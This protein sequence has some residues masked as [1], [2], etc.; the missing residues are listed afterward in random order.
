MQITSLPNQDS[1]LSGGQAPVLGLDVWEHAYYLKCQNRRAEYIENFFHVIKWNQIEKNYK[2]ALKK[3]KVR[4]NLR[5][6]Y[7]FLGPPEERNHNGKSGT[8]A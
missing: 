3:E 2:E 6:Q 1:P 8:Q 4:K 5:Y 7:I